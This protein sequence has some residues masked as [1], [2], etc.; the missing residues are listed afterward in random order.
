MNKNKIVIVESSFPG[1]GVQYILPALLILSARKALFTKIGS[2]TIPLNVLSSPFTHWL[3]PI[4]I[5]CWAVFAILI[6]S[7]NIFHLG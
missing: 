4:G 5:L 1:V 6:V 7:L 2:N 3:W